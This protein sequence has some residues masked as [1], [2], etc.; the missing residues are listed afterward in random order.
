[1]V[2]TPSGRRRRALSAPLRCHSP[3][4]RPGYSLRASTETVPL[5]SSFLSHTSSFSNKILMMTR[6]MRGYG[7]P[8][9]PSWLSTPEP[10]CRWNFLV[11]GTPSF[12]STEPSTNRIPATQIAPMATRLTRKLPHRA[13][14]RIP[15]CLSW[16]RLCNFD[17]R[18]F[19]R[20][21][22]PS[23]SHTKRAVSSIDAGNVTS[24]C[25]MFHDWR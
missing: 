17:S 18:L 9:R 22:V 21:R 11:S 12:L 20:P 1:M 8:P 2:D 3:P 15:C 13:I 14:L 7:P 4:S 16:V 6:Y 5:I 19:D 24:G 10:C 23:D 25:V